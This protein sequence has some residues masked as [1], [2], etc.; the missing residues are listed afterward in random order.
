MIETNDRNDPRNQTDT[1][2]VAFDKKVIVTLSK[3][4]PLHTIFYDEHIDCDGR[5]YY[6]DE[7][8]GTDYLEE[9][10]SEHHSIPELLD[11]LAKQA[12]LR[13]AILEREIRLMDPTLSIRRQVNEVE[14]WRTIIEDCAGWKVEDVDYDDV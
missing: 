9:F 8:D 2:P 11:I 3:E 4:M 5:T 7:S 10:K 13:I 14:K 6:T 12:T 1:P